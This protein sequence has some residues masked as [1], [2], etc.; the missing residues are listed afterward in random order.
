MPRSA[1]AAR[2]PDGQ[3]T[4]RSRRASAPSSASRPKLASLTVDSP[5]DAGAILDAIRNNEIDAL[6]IRK[7]ASDHVF[8][9]RSMAELRQ[10]DT[11]LRHAGAERRM[12]N[13]AR[14]ELER[15]FE[16]LATH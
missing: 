15:R 11:E 2:A 1:K 16:T 12:A 4:T 7:D 9:L 10:A 13:A 8:A 6:V 14:R 5:P 3:V